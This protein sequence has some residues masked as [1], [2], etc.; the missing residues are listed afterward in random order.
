MQG[1][2]RASASVP[3]GFRGISAGSLWDF[4][5]LMKPSRHVCGVL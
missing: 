3:I 1:R 4:E 2:R 5:A